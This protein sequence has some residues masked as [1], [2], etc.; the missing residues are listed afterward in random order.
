MQFSNFNGLVSKSDTCLIYIAI[1]YSKQTCLIDIVGSP[2]KYKFET[3]NLSYAEYCLA[4]SVF[5]FE[6]AR[7]DYV[8]QV[9][10][11]MYI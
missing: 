1:S 8:L 5:S 7:T 4:I 3:S 6:A 2:L 11:G 9:I 10:L